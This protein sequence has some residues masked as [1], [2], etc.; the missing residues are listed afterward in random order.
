MEQYRVNK[1]YFYWLER[2]KDP[3]ALAREYNACA[4]IA[5]NCLSPNSNNW[6]VITI[7]YSF[8]HAITGEKM[9]FVRI[10]RASDGKGEAEH[11]TITDG[12]LEEYK[13]YILNPGDYEYIP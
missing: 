4:A 10:D 5:N 6:E 12:E 3:E 8:Y 1:M 11:K 2:S 7:L 9:H 13:K